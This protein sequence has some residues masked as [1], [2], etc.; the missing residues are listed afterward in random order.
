MITEYPLLISPFID[1]NENFLTDEDDIPPHRNY[2]NG[3]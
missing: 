2:K 3:K 1:E